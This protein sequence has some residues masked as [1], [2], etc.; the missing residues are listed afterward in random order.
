MSFSHVKGDDG[1][2]HVFK[3]W[4]AL[5]GISS[6]QPAISIS[7][8]CFERLGRFAICHPPPPLA[9]IVG[10]V[11]SATVHIPVGPNT[12]YPWTAQSRALLSWSSSCLAV[13]NSASLKDPR[14]HIASSDRSCTTCS[15]SPSSPSFRP[16]PA[17][18]HDMS[19]FS[20]NSSTVTAR[21]A[22]GGRKSRGTKQFG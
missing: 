12:R 11:L 19:G 8:M 22:C 5:A 21:L 1:D 16:T 4:L 18:P 13:A 9:A 10:A 3:T 7:I 6:E 20:T 14:L 17:C 15:A 2:V